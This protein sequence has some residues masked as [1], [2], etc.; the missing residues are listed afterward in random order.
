MHFGLPARIEEHPMSCS[1]QKLFGTVLLLALKFFEQLY[2]L[3]T[4]S[5][6]PELIENHIPKKLESD[7]VALV[8]QL[9]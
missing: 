7:N 4:F 8:L 6:I 2:Q 5:K 9:L 3:E 1:V